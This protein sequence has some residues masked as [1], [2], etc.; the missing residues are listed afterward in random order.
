[1]EE[2]DMNAGYASSA[3]QLEDVRYWSDFNRLFYVPRTILEEC[4]TIQVFAF[5]REQYHQPT[6]HT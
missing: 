1:M 3:V 6:T 5:V 2:S 4:E